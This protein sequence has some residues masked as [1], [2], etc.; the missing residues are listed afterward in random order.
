MLKK[1][2]SKSNT[3]KKESFKKNKTKQ[4]IDYVAPNFIRLN[5]DLVKVYS[6]GLCMILITLT[7]S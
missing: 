3:F 6:N 4:G 7:I 1:K 2:K 5:M